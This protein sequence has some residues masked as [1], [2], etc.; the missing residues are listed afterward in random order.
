MRIIPKETKVRIEFFKGVELMDVLVGAVGVSL[1]A[2][3]FVSN[4]PYKLWIIM[5]VVVIFAALILP[6]DDEKG[7]MMIYNSV[8]HLARPKRLVRIADQPAEAS[9][10]ASK[11][12]AKP[13]KEKKAKA[14]KPAKPVKE[15]KSKAKAEPA[16]PAAEPAKA[17]KAAGSFVGQMNQQL[18]QMEQES[19][20]AQGKKTSAKSGK[21]D[22]FLRKEESKN[23]EGKSKRPLAV[24]DITPFTGVD[25]NFIEYGGKYYGIAVEVPSVE[26]DRKSVV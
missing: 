9:E 14:E 23:T 22:A 15:K 7:Y 18:G 25:G 17:S 16:A 5:G 21:K 6:L 10:K 3:V 8:K 11:K 19:E 26:L 4:L 1:A 2:S 12:K 20:A 24:E 13:A